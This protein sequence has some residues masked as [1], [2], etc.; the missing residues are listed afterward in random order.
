ML[1]F[2]KS[3]WPVQ[4]S[5]WGKFIPTFLLGFF[6]CF[7]YYLLRPIKDTVVVTMSESGA[8]VIPFLKLWGVLPAVIGVALLMSL[9]YRKFSRPT[10]F[11]L[12]T[13]AFLLYFVIFVLFLYPAREMLALDS[14]AS[15]LYAHLPAGFA[16]PIELIRQW[17]ISLF[18]VVCELWKVV[19][20]LV[21]FWGYVN[22]RTD[23]SEAQRLYAPLM[24]GGSLS[25]WLA[26]EITIATSGFEWSS[27]LTLL[28]S[29]VAVVGVLCLFL[30]AWVHRAHGKEEGRAPPSTDPIPEAYKPRSAMEA[31]RLVFRSRI[32]MC[33]AVMI[34]A[35]Y[36]AF[37]LVEVL[38]KEQ[39]H[40]LYPNPAD[41]CGCTGRVLRWT[42]ILG[43]IA[44]LFIS[45]NVVR[46]F[47][48]LSITLITPAVLAI[49]S[50]AFFFFLFKGPIAA[51]LGLAVFFGALHNCTSRASRQAFADPAKEMAY[52]PLSSTLQTQG[53]TF[54]DGVSPTIGK[55][56]G[57]V[58]QQGLLLAVP[59]IMGTAPFAAGIVFLSLAAATGA[60]LAVGR[61]Y[62]AQLKPT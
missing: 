23:L 21:L 62:R 59:D 22:S 9:L 18:Y 32:L 34:I 61:P 20:L 47:G 36:V 55:T 38:W 31:L 53:K 25:G 14:F 15:T 30:F 58:I 42:G 41:F 35:E 11:Y 57:A 12:G 39:M 29:L 48:W 27:M 4:R 40:R 17:P 8:A 46:R 6:I 24:V 49:T 52:L 54:V 28:I 50:F 56:G 3:L 5:E 26:G 10:V 16:A 1:Q 43:I 19:V 13:S 2:L 44:S 37:N 51:P 45:G 7:N 60:V 33:I